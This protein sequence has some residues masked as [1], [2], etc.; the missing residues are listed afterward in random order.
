MTKKPVLYIQPIGC[1]GPGLIER[2]R[3][4]SIPFKMCRPT[5]GHPVPSNPIDYSAI[6]CLGGPMGVYETD[7]YPWIGD[8]IALLQESIHKRV[9]CLGICFGAQIL[10]A[11]AGAKVEPTGIKEIGWEKIQLTPAGREDPLLS[12]FPHETEVF[13]WHGDRW[14]L[15]EG[16]ELL[17]F[18]EKCDHQIFRLGAKHFGFQ[19]H[20]EVLPEDPPCWSEAYFDELRS[21]RD[22]PTAEGIV[23]QTR[24]YH[25]RLEPVASKVFQS[26]WDLVLG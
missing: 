17:A 12:E 14:E 26:F 22:V 13:H 24:L 19:C 2:T 6:V 16:A 10:A 3:P 11:A 21:S 23:E 8:L 9:P 5:I 25:P 4:E 1:E 15:P 7:K 20:L 18:S